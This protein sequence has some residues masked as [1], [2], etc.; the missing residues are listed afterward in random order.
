MRRLLLFFL[1][2][3][4]LAAAGLPAGGIQTVQAQQAVDPAVKSKALLAQLTP[5]E[6][7][8]QLFIATFKGR[9]VTSKDSKIMDM[10]ANHYLG[11]VILRSANDNFMGPSGTVDD[12]SKLT[13]TL[14]TDKYQGSQKT[15]VNPVNKQQ[16]VPRFI[17]LL[18]GVSQDGDLYPFDQIF[19]GVTPLPN[20]MA[21]TRSGARPSA[22]DARRRH[23]HARPDA[24]ARDR[25]AQGIRSRS[26]HGAPARVHRGRW[27][28]VVR[29][30]LRPT[31][32]GGRTDR[33][34]S[35]C[36]ARRLGGGRRLVEPRGASG[37]LVDLARP[38]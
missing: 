15:A 9:D 18:I 13:T 25:C 4:L 7:V 19:N 12:L 16:F 32:R 28:L 14:Q 10:V 24:R 20:L 37:A 26:G 17:P 3:M 2:T 38:A 8:G 33:C 30:A 36:R 22:H 11:G 23:R 31:A 5:E 35:R 34:G 1:M 27:R 21:C 29:C 6:K